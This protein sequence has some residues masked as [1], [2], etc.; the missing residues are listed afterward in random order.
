MKRKLRK[1][2]L[3]DKEVALYLACLN[4][5]RTPTDISKQTGI[6]RATVYHYLEKLKKRGLITTQVR[7][8]RKL[9]VSIA[10]ET[11]LTI[12]IEKDK[13]ALAYKESFFADLVQD[14]QAFSR[15]K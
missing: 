6:N 1:F 12:L 4:E 2:G 10:P 3:D 14:L 13:E 5:G 15:Q 8:K 7:W 9:I 11:A